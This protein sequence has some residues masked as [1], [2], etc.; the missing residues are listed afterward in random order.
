MRVLLV[1]NPLYDKNRLVLDAPD[2]LLLRQLVIV[3]KVHRSIL[4]ENTGSIEQGENLR[5][6]L[7]VLI[8]RRLQPFKFLCI[9]L[10]EFL[11]TLE[12][13]IVLLYF[14]HQSETWIL[15]VDH[16]MDLAETPFVKL[17]E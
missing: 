13:A 9:L 2:L 10:E 7:F 17:F 1:L 6:L 5:R 4:D 16:L 14:G 3:A 12:L 11:F 15:Y 8:M